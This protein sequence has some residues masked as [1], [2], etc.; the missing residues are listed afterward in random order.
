[1]Q[2][3]LETAERRAR[4]AEL[5]V[6]K[7]T[8]EMES[9]RHV[10]RVSITAQTEISQLR[11]LV[12]ELKRGGGGGMYRVS[13]ASQVG[14]TAYDSPRRESSSSGGGGGG[15]VRPLFSSS[16]LVPD[17]DTG[18]TTPSHSNNININTNTN[19]PDYIRL[20]GGRKTLDELVSTALTAAEERLSLERDRQLL[21]RE[22]EREHRVLETQNTE[23]RVQALCRWG[24][25]MIDIA[26]KCMGPFLP[27][28][29][30]SSSG[31]AATAT[32][33]AAT[34]PS[35]G[36]SDDSERI[37]GGNGV[38]DNDDNDVD[39]LEYEG[40]RHR[41][42]DRDRDREDNVIGQTVS[43]SVSSL[44]QPDIAGMTSHPGTG[45]G[46]E[47]GTSS[48]VV[49]VDKSGISSRGKALSDRREQLKKQLSELRA[50]DPTAISMSWEAAS[51]AVHAGRDLVLTIHIPVTERLAFLEWQYSAVPCEFV[52]MKLV[53]ARDGRGGAVAEG[54]GE[55]LLL[56]SEISVNADSPDSLPVFSGAVALR[57]GGD[58]LLH[59][60]N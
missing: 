25:A 8:A 44:Q 17:T 33:T 27:L 37:R 16:D 5:L 52:S 42:R 58:Q 32:A 41:D 1:M 7:L 26:S 28:D 50:S 18:T 34:D 11:E 54:A 21:E 3:Q 40:D 46:A 29:S 43:E 38:L 24:D 4:S 13:S 53:R 9:L 48:T 39:I 31:P 57:G 60:C 22:H 23:E 2:S 12:A 59:I 51:V 56:Q 20:P 55:G 10:S 30:S 49:M 45:T 35:Q 15:V 47:S 6:E 19:D 36:T 14:Y